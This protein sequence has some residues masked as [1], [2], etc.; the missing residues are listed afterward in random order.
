MGSIDITYCANP[1]NTAVCHDCR[2]FMSDYARKKHG[3]WASM[4]NRRTPE[5][6]KH[7]KQKE[8][9]KK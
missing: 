1:I 2:Y 8:R 5:C 3:Q 4:A 6:E 7:A 9:G